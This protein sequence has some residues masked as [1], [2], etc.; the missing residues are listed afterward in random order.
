MNRATPLLI[1]PRTFYFS[2]TLTTLDL[3]R[4]RIHAQGAEHL[5]VALEQN[6]VT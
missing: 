1:Q 5:A 2:Q 6:K 3:I 4:N